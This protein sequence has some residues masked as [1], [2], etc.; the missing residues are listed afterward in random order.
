MNRRSFAGLTAGAL[1]AGPALPQAA[2]RNAIIEMRYIR[3]RTGPQVQRTMDFLSKFAVPAMKRAGIA[4]FGVFNA[5]IAES[6]PFVL[7]VS[8][9]PSLADF[10]KMQGAVLGDKEMQKGWDEWNNMSELSFMRV[11]NSLLYAF[12]TMPDIEIPAAEPKRTPRIFELRTYQSNNFVAGRRKIKMFDEGEIGIFRRLGMT[13]VFFGETIV[14]QD[15]PNLT[16][17]LAFD[18][19]A[20]RERAWGAFGGDPEWKK[21]RATPGWSDAE[22]V[23]NISSAILRP[24]P[25][26]PIA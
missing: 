23:S 10:L 1:A 2:P 18:D 15:I 16:Y 26:S 19:L 9:Y 20:H 21:L 17:M 12:N 14:G 13:P 22:I 11:E 8:S 6:S 5:L 7:V 25:F 4:R 3:M 24:A